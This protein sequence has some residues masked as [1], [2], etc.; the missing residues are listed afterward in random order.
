MQMNKVKYCLLFLFVICFV[1]VSFSGDTEYSIR[2]NR[3]ELSVNDTIELQY[4][5]G[6]DGSPDILRHEGKLKLEYDREAQT[7][8]SWPYDWRYSF[9][10]Q[11]QLSGGTWSSI[12]TLSISYVAGEYV[13][14]EYR[15]FQ[16]DHN[17]DL[18]RVLIT[19]V[20]GEYFTGSGWVTVGN[21]TTD[22]TYLPTD[23][24]MELC[25]KTSQ[26][27]P[28]S[29]SQETSLIF[30]P[31][32]GV[33]D[34]HY[35]KGAESYDLE[36]VFIDSTSAEYTLVKDHISS[37]SALIGGGPEDFGDYFDESLPFRLKE[38]T[39]VNIWNT[40]YKIDVIYPPGLLFFRVRPV[41]VYT[42]YSDN[43]NQD[44][45][46]VKTAEWS[47]YAQ[48]SSQY[49]SYSLLASYEIGHLESFERDQNWLFGSN[50]A[51]DGKSVSTLSYYDGS[52]R[53]RQSLAY[54]TSDNTTLIAE[55]KFD[56]EGR[57]T[58]SLIPA[59]I[60]G[61]NFEYRT[62]FNQ[63]SSS[64]PFEKE[65]FDKTNPENLKTNTTDTTGAGQ[66]F[67]TS[68][69]FSTNEYSKAVPDAN[70]YVYSQ[71]RFNRDG[72]GRVSET[73]SV[74]QTFA[75]ENNH[76]TKYYYDTAKE[77]ELRRLFGDEVG[78]ADNYKKNIIVDPNGQGT[79]SYLDNHGRIIGTAVIGATPS[80]L[81]ALD[82]LTSESLVTPL[83]VS[84]ASNTSIEKK[85]IEVVTSLDTTALYTFSYNF[86]GVLYGVEFP[87]DT[88]QLLCEECI[89]SLDFY[90]E[91]PDGD[92]LST[93]VNSYTFNASTISC[94]GSGVTLYTPTTSVGTIGSYTFNQVGEYKIYKTL[95]V[96][97][98][99]MRDS[100]FADVDAELGGVDSFI[101]SVLLSVDVSGC[102]TDCA[103]YCEY[104][105]EFK[106]ELETG[107]DWDALSAFTQGIY[108]DSCSTETCDLNQLWD[109]T[110]DQQ[111]DADSLGEPIIIGALNQ[112]YGIYGQ[113]AD[114]ISPGGV[115]YD[116]ITLDTLFWTEVSSDLGGSLLLYPSY[117]SNGTPIGS[118]FSSIDSIQDPL[119]FQTEWVANLMP[120]HREYC[121]YDVCVR[122]ATTENAAG[123]NSIQFD[124][125]LATKGP[126]PGTPFI[127]DY[128]SPSL[129]LDPLNN[130]VIES[131]VDSLFG[132]Q[133]LHTI[134]NDFLFPCSTGG[135]DSITEYVDSVWLCLYG[136]PPSTLQDSITKWNIF[137]STYA[138]KKNEYVNM[139]KQYIDTLTGGPFSHIRGCLYY[140]DGNEIILNLDLDDSLLSD[141]TQLANFAIQLQQNSP[142]SL[143]FN[144]ADQCD[145]NVP[146]WL[147]T[148]P[149]TCQ[150]ILAANSNLL[151]DELESL[152]YNYCSTSCQTGNVYGWFYDNGSLEYDSIVDFFATNTALECGLESILIDSANISID[153][154]VSV[155]ILSLC[156]T[157]LVELVNSDLPNPSGGVWVPGDTLSGC[158]GVGSSIIV[159]SG[160][161]HN[162]IYAST[163][164]LCGIRELV[165]FTD[166]F[167]NPINLDSAVTVQNVSA[168]QIDPNM[169]YGEVVMNNGDV[170]Y[171]ILELA[172]CFVSE[173]QYVVAYDSPE[174]PS[175]TD[176]CIDETYGQAI[177]GATQTY[178]DLVNSLANAVLDSIDCMT[179]V[180]EI[181]KMSYTLREGQYTLFYYDQ[182]GNLVSTVPPEGVN[183]LSQVQFDAAYNDT[184]MQW[185]NGTVPNHEMQTIYKYNGANELIEQETP[186]GGITNFYYD[187]LFR[188]HFSQNAQQLID[189]KVSYTIFDELGRI[190]EAG[191]A[192]DPSLAALNF[193]DS[194]NN[195][196]YPVDWKKRDYTKT[197]YEEGYGF[198]TTIA[199]LLGDE[200][201]L[202]NRI[203][204]V[205]HR[206]ADYT[207]VSGQI[208]I[209]PFS[210]VILRSSYGYDYH[211]NVKKLVQTNSH[212]A[213]IG[214]EYKAFSYDF[215]LISGNVKELTYQL[216]SLDEWRHRYHYDANNRLVRAWTSDDGEEW[217]MDAKYF[218]YLHGPLARVETG[219]DKVQGTDYAYNMQGWLLGANST[220]LSSTND[221]GNDGLS[222]DLD[223][224]SGA[225]AFG[226]SLTFFAGDTNNVSQTNFFAN[227]NALISLNGV[228]GSL[229]NGNIST[230]VTAMKDVNEAPIEV[231]G[232]NYK[233]DQLQRIKNMDV[234]SVS[235]QDDFIA[236]NNFSGATSYNTNGYKTY[237]SYDKNGNLD[238]LI[239]YEQNGTLMDYFDYIYLFDG[240]DQT[241]KLG[242]VTDGAGSGVSTVD[243]DGQ[244]SGNYTYNEIGQLTADVSE[245]ITNIEWTVT[246]KVKKI[247][248][249][250]GDQVKFVYDAM[251]NRV[252]KIVNNDEFTYYVYDASGNLM[253]TYN[254][255]QTI[256]VAQ[257]STN[258]DWVID[259]L[260]IGE[261]F[262]FGS[263]KLGERSLSGSLLTTRE[264][265]RSW[266]P[267]NIV[268]T[269][270]SLTQFPENFET[271][272]RFVGGKSYELSNHLGN[273]LEVVTDRKVS[274]TTG[275]LYESDVV[276]YSDYYPFGMLLPG[277][278]GSTGDYRYGFQ[279]Q[280]MDDEIKGE[281]NSVNY[282]YR[283]HDP[284]I[285]RFFAID[286]LA[287]KYPHNSPYAFS[288]NRVVD[289]VELEG[290]EY[291]TVHIS[292]D[293]K[294]NKSL[295]RVESHRD[296]K[297]GYGPMGAGIAYQYHTIIQTGE[298]KG[299]S[300]GYTILIKN[301]HGIYQGPNNPL[302]YW[303]EK[304]KNG[305]FYGDYQF[306]PIDE[307][308][309]TA[310]QHD[311][312]Y[313]VDN[314]AGFAGVMDFK[315]TQANL[316]YILNAKKI[317]EKFLKGEDDIYT[318]KPVSMTTLKAA[319]TGATFFKLVEDRK[320][321]I[322]QNEQQIKS[323]KNEVNNLFD[324]NYMDR[325][326]WKRIGGW[327]H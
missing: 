110:S 80:N 45:E 321:A 126:W 181:Y 37:S 71:V 82:G 250:S 182:A 223:K 282:K 94:S 222:S 144:C 114:Q 308:D 277:R 106:Y 44:Y 22:N 325:E 244:S 56:F 18:R 103:S 62:N 6:F 229:Y 91:K 27:R 159:G 33:V 210:E 288:E 8:I 20:F 253:E 213:E 127:S 88:T 194:L 268:I 93:S 89:Y 304:D 83:S 172:D 259:N 164:L 36:W 25:L 166:L 171:A 186:D 11:Y 221:I 189:N 112:C 132:L 75:M 217:E 200:L 65:N 137:T 242:Y 140:D 79:A 300:S 236:N 121:H 73:S 278:H 55:S 283:M 105:A 48:T 158:I 183:P 191:E 276:S 59:P 190:I 3:G 241:N 224:F 98:D 203:G 115:F 275:Y 161:S 32:K 279:G 293:A 2:K 169:A 289:G 35:V 146:F 100:V 139:F 228:N 307:A 206:M 147:S 185:T 13:Y 269:E 246:G 97:F 262:I 4:P 299:K 50:Y 237:Y 131:K 160:A 23:I 84:N 295:L 267:P 104:Y 205:E 14:S 260:S 198:D 92:T 70:G 128:L 129:D 256:D 305:N 78:Y 195:Y 290:L 184:T 155:L 156:L 192:G 323:I 151:Y 265:T 174:I 216:D 165:I 86:N 150:T 1:D 135:N 69:T 113:M 196:E 312:D 301:S 30:A 249:G 252:I 319:N 136:S 101:D 116:D 292:Q 117:Q 326:G 257:S 54:N 125:M 123:E 74:G 316:D 31:S 318:N 111:F 173:S 324:E 124:A 163:D 41:G 64:T 180:V 273:V 85:S 167:G 179:D 170:I 306:E 285:G 46:T 141:S 107:N 220:T 157:E 219:H 109:G 317:F 51:E 243:I 67:S 153:S 202:R 60:S 134:D 72:T 302:K 225:D 17:F 178:D 142:T 148:F 266:L 68:N 291:Y 77:I 251:E 327:Q 19:S 280:E 90:I 247:T 258:V 226:F 118:A 29:L 234:Y 271:E 314:L 177:F 193:Q 57:Q 245:D 24:H 81:I 315:S 99:A 201:N 204:A 122:L 7:D 218:Y 233:Y 21:A 16:E 10:F 108:L 47:Y 270:R 294:G 211:G 255:T 296:E 154:T 188:L 274:D 232:N 286:P 12:D 87:L 66:Y 284:R 76:T 239:R 215:D 9:G 40:F 209:V 63:N 119:K 138:D 309:A 263:N 58:V 96:D 162:I 281:G 264:F 199:N 261:Q 5:G 102:F 298:L 310:M 149:D 15:L 187:D 254:R 34:W 311:K 230:M 26:Y 39:R 208:E 207:V 42:G 227:T 212:L 152:L 38:P 322:K 297:N 313:D 43:P 28:L 145:L 214:H 52:L 49:Q 248:K 231:L 130:S 197:Y 235:N 320:T 61:R 240:G 287:P 175:Y 303:E 176:D 133:W 238:E 143:S 95:S 120:Y 272:K 168:S 53:G